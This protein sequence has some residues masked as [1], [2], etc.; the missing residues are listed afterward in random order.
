MNSGLTGLKLHLNIESGYTSDDTLLQSYLDIAIE[1]VETYIDYDLSG[2]TSIPL[3]LQQ[4][5]ILLA[6]HFYLNRNMVTF[7]QGYELPYSFKFL[8]DPYKNI[9]IE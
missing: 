5:I 9:T 7:G 4:S 1:A 6:S 3:P 8:L 2:Y